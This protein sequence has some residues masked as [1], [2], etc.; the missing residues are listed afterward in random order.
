[1]ITSALLYYLIRAS[2]RRIRRGNQLLQS[3]V[4]GTTDAIFVKDRQGRFLLVNRPSAEILGHPPDQ[5]LGKYNHDLLPPD[6]AQTLSTTDQQIMA[7]GQTQQLQEIIPMEGTDHIFW[8]TKYVWRDEQGQ[9]QGL[10]GMTRDVTELMQMQTERQ[11]LI[12][13]LQKQTQELQAL[14]LVTANAISTLDLDELLDVLLERVISVT[15]A[16]AGFILLVEHQ[17]LTL[18]ARKVKPTADFVHTSEDDIFHRSE[19]LTGEGFASTIFKTRKPLYVED[20]SQDVR[21]STPY[22]QRLQSCSLLGVPLVRHN[23][24]L[25]VLQIEWFVCQAFEERTLRLLEITAERCA[26]AILNAQLYA[27]SQRLNRQLQTQVDRMP[28]GL[29]LMDDQFCITNWNPAA[30]QIFGYSKAEVLGR[31]PRDL[32][33]PASAYGTVEALAAKLSRGDM[34]AHSTH[35]N[36]TK[37]GRLIFC[38]WYNTP[39]FDHA[40]QFTGVL[41]MVQDVTERKRTQEQLERLAYYH[42]LTG[43]PRRSLLLK[44]L[45]TLMAGPPQA[46][47]NNSSLFA[48]FYLECHPYRRLKYSLGHDLADAFLRAVARRL[49]S[50]L[51]SPAVIA[52]VETDEFAVLLE[53]LSDLSE[54]TSWAETLQRELRQPLTILGHQ[55]FIAPRLGIALSNQGHDDPAAMLKAADVAMNQVKTTAQTRAIYTPAMAERAVLA[56]QLDT[57][58]RLALERQ[59]FELYYQPIMQLQ[60]HQLLGF[61]AL[62]RWRHP[63]RGLVNPD[64]FIPAAEQTGLILPIGEWVLH[65]ACQQSQQ[66]QERWGND[67]PLT[68]SVNLS[69]KQIEQPNLL[70][71]I[72]NTV[73]RSGLQ[74]DQL[75]LELTESLLVERGEQITSRLKHLRSIGFQL[76]IDDF[77][78]GYSC[79]S[80]LHQFPFDGLKLDRSFVHRLETDDQSQTII[81]TLVQLA[82]NLNMQVVAEGIET[83]PQLEFL[84]QLNCQMGQG[85]YFSRPMNAIVAEQFIALQAGLET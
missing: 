26:M 19:N 2:Q 20:I 22:R 84:R 46:A 38:E 67:P 78:T 24:C 42:P 41:S 39:L 77:G 12:A 66:W 32:I 72:E 56:E 83:I 15:Q 62:L 71:Y 79:L 68:I 45:Q 31:H 23:R 61:E 51:L 74:S 36:I 43:L 82:E 58:L 44:R 50:C 75:K 4:D 80:Y 49:E 37:S 28:M 60:S 65:Q 48:V 16:D 69:A 6:I 54:A 10:I 73:Q 30:T 13:D 34:S 57:D 47:G 52:H 35:E 85:Y 29:V 53:Q 21:F 27:Q 64:D 7:K 25:G 5:I 33:V 70:T 76:I 8:S 18:K 3:I 9:V 1:M 14:N 55:L 81:C 63:Q 59:Q 40:S 17:T 11:Q